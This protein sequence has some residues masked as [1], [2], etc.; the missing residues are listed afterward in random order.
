MDQ[1]VLDQNNNVAA[2]SL[3]FTTDEGCFLLQVNK[4]FDQ[5]NVTK[6]YVGPVL[7]LE[8]DYY[9]SPDFYHMLNLLYGNKMK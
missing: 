2:V 6:S 4:V 3:I 7:F 1:Q 8:E 9:V 5:L